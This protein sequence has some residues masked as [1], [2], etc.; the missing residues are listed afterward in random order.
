[1]LLHE[2]SSHKVGLLLS[3]LMLKDACRN[4][5]PIPSVDPVVSDDPRYF[6]DEG[7]KALLDSWPAFWGSVTPSYR[8]TATYIAL[9]YLLHIE[10][11]VISPAVLR[12]V[13]KCEG[14]EGLAQLPRTALR[15]SS[16]SMRILRSSR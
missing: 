12:N 14:L 4:H 8:R 7:H 10:G 13:A 2:L 1:M 3:V 16:H 11:G 6:A 5:Y 9:A 15:R